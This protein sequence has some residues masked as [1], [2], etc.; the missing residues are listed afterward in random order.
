MICRSIDFNVQHGAVVML[1]HPCADP[2]QV[3][4]LKQLVKSCVWKYVI[5]PWNQLNTD[6]VI[7]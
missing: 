5:T 3:Q 1:Y 4:T 6:L 7:D 2:Q